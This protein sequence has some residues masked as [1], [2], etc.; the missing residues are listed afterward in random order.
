M[1]GVVQ[2]KDFT[3]NGAPKFQVSGTWYFL[4]RD[5]QP[6]EFPEGSTI[7]FDF[8]EFGDDRG[9]GRPRAIK[10][11]ALAQKSLGNSQS[12]STLSDVDYLRSVSNIVGSACQAG[13]IAT[14]EELEKWCLAA[15][16]G[17]V[18]AMSRS[19]FEE[20]KEDKPD[21]DDEIPF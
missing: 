12:G 20:E 6:K 18:R 11:W 1:Q 17:L 8:E 4:G 2:K 5:T 3:K 16:M 13:K 14:P 21:F 15:R 9:R 7:E 19:K 10:R